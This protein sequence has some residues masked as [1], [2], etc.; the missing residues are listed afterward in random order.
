MF[1]EKRSR[2]LHP[3]G[4]TGPADVSL[5]AK[6]AKGSITLPDIALAKAPDGYETLIALARLLGREAAR[7]HAGRKSIGALD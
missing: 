3:K 7:D 6:A 1:A 2:P 5:C 4:D